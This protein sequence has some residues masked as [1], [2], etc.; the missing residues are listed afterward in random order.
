ML[1]SAKVEADKRVRVCL[2]G[3]AELLYCTVRQG[4]IFRFIAN[5]IIVS[6]CI[7]CYLCRR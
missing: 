7:S 4:L 3:L 1:G 2:G 6:F 5:G